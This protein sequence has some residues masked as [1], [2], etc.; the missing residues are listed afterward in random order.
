MVFS[1]QEAV[2]ER[3][4]RVLIDRINWEVQPGERWW[5][6]GANGSGKTTL[7]EVLIGQYR[8]A[9]GL[10]LLP[11]EMPF[12][13]FISLVAMVRRDFSLNH[14]FNRSASFYQQ[15]YFSLGIEETPL[16][17]DFITSETGISKTII[18]SAAGDFHADKLMDKHIVSLSTGEG[19]RIL[20]LMLWLAEKKIICFDDPYAGLDLNGRELV[21]HTLENLAAKQVTILV[22]GTDI[23]PPDYID[24]VLYIKDQKITYCGKAGE[25]RINGMETEFTQDDFTLLHH[26]KDSFSYSFHVAAGMNNITV[27]YDEK[28]LLENFSWQIIQGEKW[29]LTGANGSGKS[30]LMSLIYGDNP[31]AYAYELVVFDRIRGTGETIWDVKRPMGYYSSELQQFF[32]RNMTLYEAVLTGYSD[33]LIVRDNLSKEHYRQ[34][35]ELIEAAGISDNKETLLFRLSFSQCRLALVCRALVKHPPLVILDE[36]CQGLDRKTTAIVNRLTEA[37]CGDK[38]KTLIYVTHQ[39]DAIPGIINRRLELFRQSSNDF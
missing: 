14:L 19:R 25:F 31:M 33:H 23:Q 29:L 17:I 15:R 4:D 32:P 21:N 8:L 18:R 9:G 12:E 34:A 11:D 28:T 27:C 16:V 37:V 26:V 1:L 39:T 30:T 20:L 38:R 7:L 5:I 2:V 22:T 6:C 36:P 10:M 35:D 24:H 3:N 13:K